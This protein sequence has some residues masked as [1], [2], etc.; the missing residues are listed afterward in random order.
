MVDD[1]PRAQAPRSGRLRGLAELA[2]GSLT[3]A[4]ATLHGDS[5]QRRA[6]V[7]LDLADPAQRQFGDYEL[8]EQ[9]GEGGMGVVYR[10]RHVPLNRVVAVKLLSAG[11]WASHDFIARFEREARHAARMQHPN[12]VTVFEVG[13]VDGLHF[14]SMRLVDGDSLST[15]L[16]RGDRFAA[17]VA[18]SLM[19]TVAEAVAYAHSLGVLHLDLKPGNVLI[20]RD[21][22]PHVADFGLARE[23]DGTQAV[24]NDE[25][26]GTPAYMAPEQTRLHAQKLT[27]ATDIWELGAILYELLTGVP[28]F[29]ADSAEDTLRLVEMGQVRAPRRWRP[30]L[31]LD[32]QAIVMKALDK[33]PTQRYPSARAF[34]DELARYIEGRPVQARPLTA[35]QRVWRWARRE[36]RL[37]TLAFFAFAALAAGFLATYAQSRRVAAN[38]TRAEHTLWLSRTATAQ[39]EIAAGDAY[40]ALGNAV[41]NLRDME[42]HGDRADAALERLRIGTVLANAPQLIDAIPLSKQQITALAISPDGKSVAVVTGVRTVQLIDV[43]TG[44][45]LWQVTAKPDSFGMTAFSLNRWYMHLHFSSDGRRL[46][47]R[48]NP[49]GAARAE[50]TVLYPHP[51]DGILIDATHGTQ[52]QPPP[53]FADFLAVDY[54]DDGRYALLFDK[55]GDVQRWRTLPWAADGDLVHIDGLVATTQFGLQLQDEALLTSD[56][57]TMVLVDPSKLRLRSF[58]AQHMRLRQTL[59]LTTEQDRA[60]AWAFRHDSRQLAIGTK[61]GQVAVWD[62]ESGKATWAHARFNGWISRLRYSADDTRI[63]AVA[64]EPGEMGV[65]DASSLD[66]VALPVS[67]GKELDP[68]YLDDAD[69]GPDASTVI[70]FQ[71][72]T[73]AIVWRLPDGG[74]PLRAPVPVAPPMLATYARFALA[75]DARSHLMATSDNGT[76]K[77]W[78][79]RWTPFVGGTA[80]PMVADTLRFD[81][82]HLVAADGRRVYVFDVATGVPVGKTI[83]LP[84]APTYAGLDG[85]GTRLIAIAGR[86]LS[87]WNWRNA[88]PCWPVL[89]L[90]D[91]PLRLGLA[92]RAP[93]LAVSTGSNAGGIF[94]EHVHVIDLATGRQHGAPIRVQGPLGALRL[95]ADGRRLLVFEHRNTISADGN[96]VRVIDTAT[97]RVMQS[98][99]HAERV[100]THSDW[101]AAETANGRDRAQ[102]EVAQA[103]IADARFA[104]DGSVWSAS[105][106][107]AWGGGPDGLTI[108]HW[109]TT[110]KLLREF[111]VDEGAE[112]PQLLL[113]GHDVIDA[114]LATE[115]DDAGTVIRSLD[116]PRFEN[117]VNVSALSP[118]G[119][120]L[121][122][123]MLDGVSLFVID[124]NQ[125]LVPDFKLALPNHDVVQQL[126]FAPDGSS[127]VGRTMVGHWFRWRIAADARPV[128]E[129]KQDLHL[130][131]LK[132]SGSGTAGL[133]PDTPRLTEAERHALRAA[134][135][136]PTPQFVLPAA[137][138]SEPAAP[139]PDLRYRPLD[140]DAIANVEPRT[141]MNRWANVALLPQSLPDLPRGLQRYDG[142]DFRLGRG[143][144]LSGTPL[145][146]L[147]TV[148]PAKSSPLAIAPQHIATVD[149]LVFQLRHITGEAGAVRLRYA[150]GSE[151]VLQI[152]AGHDTFSTFDITA[153]EN[154][155][156]ARIGWL[157]NYPTALHGWGMHDSGEAAD[158]SSNVVRLPNPEPDKTVVGISL[159]SPPTASPGLLF[160]AVTLER[161]ATDQRGTR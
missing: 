109:D 102:G 142:V 68:G 148:F 115:F 159:E 106:E 83:A 41:A 76:L 116:V 100:P 85:S 17:K 29:R 132:D 157:G 103:H 136:G 23:L 93:M 121:A 47:S 5:A 69:F 101:T 33:D 50:N 62:L 28:P 4:D 79:V 70:T 120:L 20:D 88:K 67:L 72:A 46:I 56:G 13:S 30:G 139:V 84:E 44:K 22:V 145:N 14:F 89:E 77:L 114:F 61:S 37:A 153:L 112:N 66:R 35:V 117:R 31:P 15:L 108:R 10:A 78:R 6:A 99:L 134:D 2:F 143:V 133:M 90:P 105:G 8:L 25:V 51:V 9:I 131:I 150:D 27:A 96:V 104:D 11:M 24:D 54:S 73:H 141:Q 110:G 16:K 140:I 144:Q 156:K 87:C 40:R 111:T 80:T 123:G 42:A 155:V 127:L 149:L 98:L 86:E 137:V 12:I 138:N 147:N 151:R 71:W 58:D 107:T 32:L 154:P 74:F 45:Q 122:L 49:V 39:R 92:A 95:S 161:V 124:R 57:T 65:F 160:L 7:E 130:R 126:A 97:G 158:Y 55:H 18:A 91:S 63:L 21:G 48:A 118:D 36:P 119:R 34:A 59:D 146:P 128:A 19:R 135:P 52:V 125:R 1:A 129:I 26:S 43:A 64:N 75:H 82:R 38:A 53:Q 3:R 113:H 60:T 94:F 81:G 152:R